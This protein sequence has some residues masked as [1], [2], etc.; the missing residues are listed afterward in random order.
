[1]LIED[2]AA[3]W[4]VALLFSVEPS[5]RALAGWGPGLEK[6]SGHPRAWAR[7]MLAWL[8]RLDGDR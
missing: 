6:P 5:D 1:M 8:A 3:R 2:E 4:G 7:W